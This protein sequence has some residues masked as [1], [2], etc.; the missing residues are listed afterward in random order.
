MLPAQPSVGRTA[1]VQGFHGSAHDTPAEG[2]QK[3]APATRQTLR[4]PFLPPDT[5]Q[6]PWQPFLLI[7]HHSSHFYPSDTA[8]AISGQWSD[9]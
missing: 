5:H 7:R 8:V 6:T 4:Q 1:M 2:P 9:S 3:D